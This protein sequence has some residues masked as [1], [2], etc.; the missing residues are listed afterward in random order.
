MELLDVKLLLPGSEL[1]RT[2][3]VTCDCGYRRDCQYMGVTADRLAD[4]HR[5]RGERHNVVIHV[6]EAEPL[7]ADV[8]RKRLRVQRSTGI[9]A[10]VVSWS[11]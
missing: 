7:T 4:Q 5:A 6:T 3:I 9:T 11:K 8:A 2:Y 10:S 1:D